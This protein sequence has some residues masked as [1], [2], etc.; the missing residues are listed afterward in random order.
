MHRSCTCDHKKSCAKPTPFQTENH[1]ALFTTVATMAAPILSYHYPQTLNASGFKQ[2]YGYPSRQFRQRG[3]AP[4][5]SVAC[6]AGR[7]QY[8]TATATARRHVER[9]VVA[10]AAT[11]PASR[12]PR[13][14]SRSRSGRAPNAN[15]S[16][17][18]QRQQHGMEPA[19]ASQQ[20]FGHPDTRAA[21]WPSLPAHA[22]ARSLGFIQIS[23]ELQ[24]CMRATQVLIPPAA[25]CIIHALVPKETG[26]ISL[27]FL[28]RS[29]H[30]HRRHAHFLCAGF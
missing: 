27:R 21:M 24:A 12:S 15:L 18:K 20:A 26:K 5:V 25:S 6:S 8:A 13:P 4:S 17:G 16:T 22:F 3:T 1:N 9:H 10:P 29:G 11:C 23:S 7:R 19:L 2:G 28:W 30:L 14:R